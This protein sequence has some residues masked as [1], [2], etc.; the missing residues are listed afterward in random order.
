MIILHFALWKCYWPG[1]LKQYKI[2]PT[3]IKMKCCHEHE[4][5]KKNL[6]LPTVFELSPPRHQLGVQTNELQRN[7]WS[8]S[9]NR[10]KPGCLPQPRQVKKEIHNEKKKYITVIYE[11]IV[12]LLGTYDVGRRFWILPRATWRARDPKPRHCSVSVRNRWA[13]DTQSMTRSFA[14]PPEVHKGKPTCDRGTVC[15][16]IKRSVWWTV[17][18]RFIGKYRGNSIFRIS[19]ET[20]IGLKNRVLWKIGD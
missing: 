12:R 4:T 10:F 17:P 11:P 8:T 18:D 6:S 2:R 16:N 14:S 20:K 9:L 1:S 7:F 3:A 13:G 5:E 19:G 15:E